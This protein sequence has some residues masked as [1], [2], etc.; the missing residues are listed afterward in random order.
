M[1]IFLHVIYGCFHPLKAA[2]TQQ[3]P[4]WDHARP[5]LA[6][7]SCKEQRSIQVSSSKGCLWSRHIRECARCQ[8]KKPQRNQASGEQ[9]LWCRF[10]S[11]DY[12][13]SVSSLV[14]LHC[15]FPQLP[16][17][18]PSLHESPQ[19]Y[20]CPFHIT[21]FQIAFQHWPPLQMTAASEVPNSEL[22][23]EE[24]DWPRPSFQVI[25]SWRFLASL[26]L[27]L[28]LSQEATPGSMSVTRGFVTWSKKCCPLSRDSRHRALLFFFF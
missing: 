12:C 8:G 4:R 18:A 7:W 5:C 20:P 25:D 22:L 24:C 9:R 21:Q 6:T 1:P 10:F 26:W 23:G 27:S 19:G 14:S 11:W 3:R 13:F 16:L 17:P 2:V 15:Y 28:P